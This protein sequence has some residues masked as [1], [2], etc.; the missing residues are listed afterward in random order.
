MYFS[1]SPCGRHT[2]LAKSKCGKFILLFH[3]TREEKANIINYLKPNTAA[4]FDDIQVALLKYV[5]D[6]ISYVLSNI[7]NKMIDSE[8]F[9]E[10]LKI[11]RFRPIHKGGN[12]YTA[13]NYR[14]I[15]VL[16]VLPKV[17]EKNYKYTVTKFFG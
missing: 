14:P 8:I 9:P 5:S 3:T 12:H 6:I 13:N 1:S 16:P 11:A 7:G 15:S 4:G 17:Y 10:E 2:V